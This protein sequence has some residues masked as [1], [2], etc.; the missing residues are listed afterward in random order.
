MRAPAVFKQLLWVAVWRHTPAREGALPSCPN[1]S[2]IAPKG[3]NSR[4]AYCWVYFT[5]AFVRSKMP[6]NKAMWIHLKPCGFRS[7]LGLVT[8]LHRLKLLHG[9]KKSAPFSGSTRA[10][11]LSSLL[12]SNKA[13]YDHPSVC[14]WHWSCSKVWGNDWQACPR[15]R[16]YQIP[17][18]PTQWHYL[19]M[20]HLTIKHLLM[21]LRTF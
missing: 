2:T 19:A 20:I 7:N 15:F 11:L 10:L 16:T 8:C 5:N 14:W 1:P 17:W 13:K 18:N 12:T 4:L 21:L 3:A 9:T 6:A